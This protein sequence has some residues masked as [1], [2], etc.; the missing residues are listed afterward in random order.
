MTSVGSMEPAHRDRT[1]T[2]RGSETLLLDN[3]YLKAQRLDEKNPEHRK[4]RPLS[5]YIYYSN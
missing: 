1:H 2:V 4:S 3:P 5:R